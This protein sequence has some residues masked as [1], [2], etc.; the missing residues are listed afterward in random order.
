MRTNSCSNCG[1]KGHYFRECQEPITSLGMIIYRKRS[2][3]EWLLVRR[4]NSLGMMEFMRGKY[5]LRD[6]AGIQTLIDQM[7]LSERIEIQTK[8]FSE[9]WRELWGGGAT[10]RYNSEYEQACAK[11]EVLR[12]LERKP[13]L[14]MYCT[15]ST[16]AWTEPEWGF[17]KGRRTSSESELT[18]ALRETWEEAGVKSTD[19]H[20]LDGEPIEEEYRGSNGVIYRHKYWI[21]EIIAS[22]SEG[23]C[24]DPTN[25]EQQRE[26][27]DVRWCSYKDA[28][29]LIRPYNVEKKAALAAAVERIK[30]N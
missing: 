26:I 9:L 15:A 10:R 2:E 5:E 3:N 12:S 21:A 23:I 1:K 20:I 4:R 28:Q 25:K 19:L 29:T 22:A 17:P 6:E 11:F 27:G 18:C 7:T 8:D 13:N 14:V 24:F 16:T 30:S